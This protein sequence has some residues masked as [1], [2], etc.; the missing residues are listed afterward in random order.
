MGIL[1]KIREWVGGLGGT[2][3]GGKR[4]TYR[5][6]TDDGQEI[7]IDSR[8]TV[9]GNNEATAFFTEMCGGSLK[10]VMLRAGATNVPMPPGAADPAGAIEAEAASSR[11]LSAA[12]VDA[13]RKYGV[14][15]SDQSDVPIFAKPGTY[16]HVDLAG[17]NVRD[18]P[19]EGAPLVISSEEAAESRAMHA[20][21]VFTVFDTRRR[22]RQKQVTVHF[23]GRGVI[24]AKGFMR[25][26]GSMGR[27]IHYDGEE[28]Q[29]IIHTRA[30]SWAGKIHWCS[31]TERY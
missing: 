20:T 10:E 23:H 7:L 8:E 3:G 21:V 6:H 11:A 17:T 16:P 5:T 25:E 15:V 30:R 24:R 9:I 28:I 29:D 1:G 2:G 12:Q 27:P 18:E 22:G 26:V 14:R 4:P 31:A 19:A 13:F